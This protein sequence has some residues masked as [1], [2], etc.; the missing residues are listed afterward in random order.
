MIDEQEYRTMS[1]NL[2]KHTARLNKEIQDNL[3][4]EIERLKQENAELQGSLNM[5][6]NAID[7][8]KSVTNSNQNKKKK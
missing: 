2:E 4:K 5:L 7:F 8:A 3:E 1:L 6:R